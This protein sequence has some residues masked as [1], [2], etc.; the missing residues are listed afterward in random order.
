MVRKTMAILAVLTLAAALGGCAGK[1]GYASADEVFVKYDTDK[2]GVITKE[3][4]TAK[5]QDKQKAETAWKK[6]DAKNNGFVDR[7]L[8][9]DIPLSV[10]NDVESQDTPY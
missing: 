10:W 2:N 8:S 6:I 3:E 4:F 7:V 1:K 9:N 5:W